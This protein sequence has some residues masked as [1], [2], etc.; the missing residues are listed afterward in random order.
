MCWQKL[1]DNA[2][3]ILSLDLIFSNQFS[4]KTWPEG[5]KQMRFLDSAVQKYSK[6][7]VEI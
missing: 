3:S 6:S 1:A 2:K 4:T 5:K 7:V